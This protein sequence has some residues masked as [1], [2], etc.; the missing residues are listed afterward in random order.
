[1]IVKRPLLLVIMGFDEKLNKNK[2]KGR[3]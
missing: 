3:E 2:E 1:L